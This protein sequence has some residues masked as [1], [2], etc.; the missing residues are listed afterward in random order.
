MQLKNIGIFLLLIAIV[1]G[2]TAFN[3]SFVSAANIKTLIRDTS[4]Y[5]LISIG[6]AVV[7]IT[8]G[9]DLSIGSLIALSGVML[10]AVVNIRHEPTGFQ[11]EIVQVVRAS[12]S[13]EDPFEE[14]V[15]RLKE[16]PPDI[17]PGDQLAYEGMHKAASLNVIGTVES[18]GQVW[19]ESAESV[20]QLKPGM[21]VSHVKTLYTNPWLACLAVLVF[22]ALIGWL[23][24]ILITYAR[25]QPFVVTL[26]GLLI[27]RG[28]ARVWTGEKQYGF[29]NHLAEFKAF[30]TGA[31]FEFPLPLIG[32]AS[33]ETEGPFDLVW[34]DFP[35]IGVLLGLVTVCGWFFL[36]RTVWG[37]HL[38]ATGEN[39]Q[40]A[41]YSGVNTAGL[42][43]LAYV[44]SAVLAGLVG[45]L[46]T[47]DLNVVQPSSTG[48]F[49]E[50]YAIAAAVL[51]GCSLRGGRGA[52]IGVLAGTAVMRSLY[53]AINMLGISQEW[54]LVIIGG[55]LLLSVLVDE[56][57]SVVKERSRKTAES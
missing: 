2:V 16:I 11:S 40:A 20:R 28:V 31:A 33:G 52:V 44:V 27:Y 53:K 48:T 23:H 26:C 55:A 32:Y 49:Y 3:G 1:I 36:N 12:E 8:G 39:E 14:D 19:I 7:I 17:A 4:F 56:L 42:T 45:I 34:I 25:L 50:L 37:R 51:G 6:V 10:V 5:G 21:A 18:D 41:R 22:S 38:L 46:F 13:K 29:E 54:E 30:W 47:L 43:T 9:I 24:G 35:V 15:V 57:I